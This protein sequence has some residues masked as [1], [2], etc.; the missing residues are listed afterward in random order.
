MKLQ[1]GFTLVELMV[2]VLIIGILSSV[3]I[4]AYRDYVTRGKLSE[5]FTELAS[6]RVRLEQYF[7][8]NRT[9]VNACQPGTIA[10]L[11]SAAASKYFTYTCPILTATTFRVDA[12]GNAAQGT[13]GFT[14][15]VDQANAKQTTSVHSGWTLPS[16]NDCWITKKGGVC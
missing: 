13:G 12:T 3:A 7:Q 1:R 11:P 6:M 8:D 9:Y 16:P 5:A 10:P 15:T 14:Y 2:V 4:P